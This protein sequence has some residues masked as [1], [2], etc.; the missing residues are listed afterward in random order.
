[1]ASL[2]LIGLVVHLFGMTLWVAYL[3]ANVQTLAAFAKSKDAPRREGMLEL[4]QANLVSMDVGLT[5]TLI[6]AALLLGANVRFYLTQGWLHAK[7][8]VVALLVYVHVFLRLRYKRAKRGEEITMPQW[9]SVG[10]RLALLAILI[11]A[12]MKP[13]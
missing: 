12:L 10:L 8:V 1:M 3:F 6:G 9:V 7:L 5:L 13:F 2:R 4:T 11:L